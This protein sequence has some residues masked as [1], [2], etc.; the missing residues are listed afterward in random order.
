MFVFLLTL[1]AGSSRVIQ[2]VLAVLTFLM[3]V[4]NCG[5]AALI[6]LFALGI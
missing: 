1:I 6:T 3:M 2:M 5:Q 4:L